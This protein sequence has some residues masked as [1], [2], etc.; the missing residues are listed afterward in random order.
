[1]TADWPAWATERVEIVEP[2]SAWPRRASELIADVARRLDPWL[3]GEVEHVGSTAVPG[4][5]AKP[6]LDL[7]APVRS[8]A[9]SAEAEPTLVRADWHLV[10]GELDGRPWR[11][12]YVLPAGARRVAHLHLVEPAH[13]RWREVLWFRDHLRRNPVLAAEYARVKRVAAGQHAEDRE[14]YTRAKSAF[15]RAVLR[16]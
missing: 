11:R 3:D 5:P 13:P 1:V 2:D 16:A 8:L 4:L 14:A 7:M 12:L 9:E 15:V 6:V 10:P